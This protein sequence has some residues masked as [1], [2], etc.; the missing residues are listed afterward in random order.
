MQAD[1]SKMLDEQ[2][3]AQADRIPYLVDALMKLNEAAVYAVE[4]KL[5]EEEIATLTKH[6]SRAVTTIINSVPTQWRTKI[7]EPLKKAML[8][9]GTLKP[10]APPAEPEPPTTA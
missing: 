4:S 7:D 10:E 9:A 8:E 2:E 6:L 3:Q 5:N 1:T